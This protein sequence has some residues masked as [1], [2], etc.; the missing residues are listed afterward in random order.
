VAEPAR[1][2]AT[3]AAQHA[4][5]EAGAHSRARL[6]D[7]AEAHFAH[8]GIDGVSL[9]AINAE[10]GFGPAAVN[11]HFGGRDELLRAVLQRRFGT[12]AALQLALLVEA[13]Q[14]RRPTTTELV[15]VIATPFFDLLER[16]P[17]AGLRWLRI[18]TALA[19]ADHD[20]IV[21]RPGRDNFEER[22]MVLLERR[23]PNHGPAFLRPRWRLAILALMALLCA[24]GDEFE[25]TL[26]IRFTA[27]GFD[28]VCTTRN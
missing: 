13:E 22:L 23:F 21:D 24:A 15:G 1:R 3:S 4:R 12:I 20:L 5:R 19:Q 7:V 16:E 27:R 18:A 25:P 8:H 11:Y 28:G 17:V 10:A 26:A 2:V 9:R 6:L 14:R